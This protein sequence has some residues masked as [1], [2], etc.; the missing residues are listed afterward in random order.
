MRI[1]VRGLEPSQAYACALR[2]KSATGQ[3]HAGWDAAVRLRSVPTTREFIRGAESALE[4]IRT[5]CSLPVDDLVRRLAVLLVRLETTV[6]TEQDLNHAGGVLL[7]VDAG[8]STKLIDRMEQRK[9][10]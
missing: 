4:D 2:V 8:L 6:V 9:R 7:G 3:L 10:L 1:L 5:D